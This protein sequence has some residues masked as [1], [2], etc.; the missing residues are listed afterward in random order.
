MRVLDRTECRV[1]IRHRAGRRATLCRHSFGGV[2]TC[3]TIEW[4]RP[5]LTVPT[6]PTIFEQ[7][8]GSLRKRAPG[9]HRVATMGIQAVGVIRRKAQ[10]TAYLDANEPRLLRLGSSRQ[11]D[12][13][14]LS[15]DIRGLLVGRDIV[16]MDATKQFPLPSRSFDAVQCEHVIEH[17]TYKA[18]LAMLRECRRVLRDDGVMRILTPN[19]QFV[20]RLIDGADDPAL[21]EYVEWSNR[22]VSEPVAAVEPKDLRNACFA[23]NRLLRNDGHMFIYDEATL[24]GALETAGFSEIVSVAPGESTHPQLQGADRHGDEVGRGFNE[25]ETLAVEASA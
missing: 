25:L 19:L 15:A 24:R 8:D 9:A 6:K 17:V 1:H 10:I 5:L 16:F 3:D 2:V 12:P 21:V 11:V 18:G 4:A 23:A 14:W 22:R 7:V 13:G 20:R